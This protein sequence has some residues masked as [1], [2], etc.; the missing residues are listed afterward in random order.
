MR[1]NFALCCAI[2]VMCLA[3]HGLRFSDFKIGYNEG[4][5]ADVVARHRNPLV[6]LPADADAVKAE[7]AQ[8][9]DV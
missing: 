5:L 9:L 4:T 7:I 3:S 2:W 8:W 6:E 1:K